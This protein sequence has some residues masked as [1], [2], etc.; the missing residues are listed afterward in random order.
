[1]QLYRNRG[2]VQEGNGAQWALPA[3]GVDGR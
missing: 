2:I 1:V 3:T